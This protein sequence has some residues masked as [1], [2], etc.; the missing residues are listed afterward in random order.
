[1]LSSHDRQE[2][3]LGSQLDH[4]GYLQVDKVETTVPLIATD[5]SYCPV[6]SLY[7]SKHVLST[8]LVSLESRARQL[9]VKR[10]AVACRRFISRAEFLVS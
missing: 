1:M 7:L 3:R 2:R 5:W 4:K 9:T 10:E 8:S 6:A